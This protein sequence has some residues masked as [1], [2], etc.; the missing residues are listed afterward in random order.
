MADLDIDAPRGVVDKRR[1]RGMAGASVL[2]STANLDS[3]SAMR[4]RLAAING[5]YF[6][7]TRLNQ[8]TENDMMMAIRLN[9]D[10]AGI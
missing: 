1:A 8:M 5:A 3:I 4:T 9:D 7:A 6:T 2:T 10:A